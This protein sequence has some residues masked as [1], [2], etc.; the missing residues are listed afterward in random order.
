MKAALLKAPGKIEIGEAA[1]PVLAAGEVMIAPAR[2]GVCGSDVS[3]YLGHRKAPQYPF[4]LGHEM[5][6]RVVAVSAG[7]TDLSVGQRVIVE[8]NYPCGT[9]AFCR[10]GRGNICPNKQSMGVTAPGCFAECA[11]APAAFV[12]SL[13]DA[14][15]D[16]DAA[17]IEP[18]TVSL[19]ALIQSGAQIGD[20]V[21]VVGCGV[22]GLLLIHV[23]VAQG[24]RV[25]AHDRIDRKLE[26]AARLGA[27]PCGHDDPAGLWLDGNV[28][29][30]FEC[31]GAT[32]TVEQALSAAPRGSQVVLLGLS[33]SPASFVPL[34]LVREGIR[35]APSMIYDHPSDF[36]RSIAL[37]ADGRLHPSCIV[38]DTV[39]FESIGRALETASSG[40]AGKIHAVM[41]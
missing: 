27:T 14:V 16:L 28:S 9:C 1:H 37:V 30:V 11:A 23:A 20:T 17:T 6:G 4:T 39:P 31:A 19:H 41:S 22:V 35:I 12:W 18:L 13:P 5:V 34:R 26:M 10:H 2:V 21:A 15:S 24:V 7:V 8:P 3:F 25:L 36:A 33:S 32:A 29:T 38:T 40:Q